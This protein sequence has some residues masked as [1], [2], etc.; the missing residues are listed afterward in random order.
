MQSISD[1]D[2]YEKSKQAKQS[3]VADSSDVSQ[4]KS[5]FATV[6]H[7]F[8]FLNQKTEAEQL[9]WDVGRG[10]GEFICSWV[11]R[12]RAFGTRNRKDFIIEEC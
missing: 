12:S 9:A 5:S 4:T 6:V 3:T 1:Y 8:D 7:D 10:N 11:L 2:A